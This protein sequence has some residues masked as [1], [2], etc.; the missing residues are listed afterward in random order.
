MTESIRKAAVVSASFGGIDLIPQLPNHPSFYAVFYT[1]QETIERSDRAAIAS[2]DRVLTPDYPRQD[3]HP[4]LRAKY[5]KIQIHKLEEVFD[6]SFL[7]WSDAGVHIVDQ[8]FIARVVE[9][10]SSSAP[11]RRLAVFPHPFRSSIQLEYDYVMAE[12][13]HGNQYLVARY[14]KENLTGQMNYYRKS[15]WDM[16][17][18]LLLGG[19][20]IVER[21]SYMCAFLDEWWDHNLRFSIQ[22]QLSLPVVLKKNFIEPYIF[23][24]NLY[25]NPAIK[26]GNH[27]KIV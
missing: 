4:R 18:R 24:A 5:F 7:V 21:N 14:A 27:I 9:R 23:E 11:Y 25:N 19:F 1:D 3:L 13:S 20:W 10:L 6:F 17:G 16:S 8:G 15:G 26:V 22:D 12:I 2:W